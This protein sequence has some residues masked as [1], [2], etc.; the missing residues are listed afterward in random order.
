MD[1]KRATPSR[2]DMER[3]KAD[4]L[5]TVAKLRQ[6]AED[7]KLQ[8]ELDGKTNLDLYKMLKSAL[9]RID[10]LEGTVSELAHRA[11]I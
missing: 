10:E 5:A 8:A 4:W 6:E 7:A 3:L 11:G 1:I 2:D 9:T